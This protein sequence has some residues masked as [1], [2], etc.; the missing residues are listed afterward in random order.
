[1]AGYL[2]DGRVI[3]RLEPFVPTLIPL[4]CGCRYQI[5]ASR[6]G[7]RSRQEL[8]ADTV[9]GSLLNGRHWCEIA[10]WKKPLCP[11]LAQYREREH[12]SLI[13]LC[14]RFRPCDLTS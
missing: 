14:L 4:R 13:G 8:L 9:F 12:L 3:S 10:A 6:R 5:L 11:N 2:V 7:F 1:M